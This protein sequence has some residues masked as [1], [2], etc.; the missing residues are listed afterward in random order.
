[1]SS[2]EAM[3]AENL[4][5][6]SHQLDSLPIDHHQPTEKENPSINSNKK[7]KR[8]TPNTSK[9]KVSFEKDIP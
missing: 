9:T 7:N 1:M 3:Q 5:I 8:K 4:L 6:E 2:Y